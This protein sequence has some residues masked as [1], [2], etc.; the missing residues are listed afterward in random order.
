[1]DKN[2]IFAHTQTNIYN[3]RKRSYRRTQ[4]FSLELPVVVE[5]GFTL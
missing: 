1:M 5:C 4:L 2:G 3:T